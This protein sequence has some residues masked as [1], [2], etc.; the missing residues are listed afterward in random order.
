MHVGTENGLS[1][2]FNVG[3]SLVFLLSEPFAIFH[4]PHAK[5]TEFYFDIYNVQNA[6]SEYVFVCLCVYL[7]IESHMCLGSCCLLV[8]L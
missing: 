5:V 3:F 2:G 4:A 8:L 7:V 6:L 1:N